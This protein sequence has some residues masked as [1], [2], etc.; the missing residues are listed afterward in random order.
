MKIKDEEKTA[1]HTD[2]DTFW[3]QKMSFILNNAGEKYQRLLDKVFTNKISR[4][5]GVYVDDMVIKIHNEA[6]PLRDIVET[7]QT[8]K[9]S[10]DETQ[11]M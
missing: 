10:V 2:R 7:F 1:F 11:S 5:V 9:K 8:L 4:N 3:Y 6:A